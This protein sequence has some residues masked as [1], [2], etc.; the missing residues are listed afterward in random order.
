MRAHYHITE[1]KLTA[2]HQIKLSTKFIFNQ[3][4]C[5]FQIAGAQLIFLLFGYNY[6]HI[7]AVFSTALKKERTTCSIS[8]DVSIPENTRTRKML[9]INVFG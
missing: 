8:S 7:R 1:Y 6:L 3:Q 5:L 4:L 2:E 9:K